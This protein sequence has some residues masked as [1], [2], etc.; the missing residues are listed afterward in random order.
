M[1][2][3]GCGLGC[4]IAGL[5]LVLVICLLPYL[6]SSIYSIV[7][8]VLQVPTASTWLWGDWISTVVD[9]S[10]PLYMIFA[11]GPICCVGTIALLLL[12]LGLVLVITSLGSGEADYEEDWYEASEEAWEQEQPWIWEQGEGISWEQPP[13]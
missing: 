9:S 1:E 4:I 8:S 10:N 13:D 3:R 2:R 7:S 11:E 5:G 12:I 6:I